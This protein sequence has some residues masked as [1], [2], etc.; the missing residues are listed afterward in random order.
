VASFKFGDLVKAKKH[1]KLFGILAVCL[2]AIVTGVAVGKIFVDTSVVA[3][4]ISGTY[5]DYQDSDEDIAALVK[6]SH[7]AM[8]S[9][10][11]AYEVFEIAQY[12]LY[13]SENFYAVMQG[14]VTPSMGSK[15][16]Q[17]TTAVKTGNNFVMNKL[18]PGGVIVGIDTNVTVLTKYDIS[19][20]K[21]S[22]NAKGTWTDRGKTTMSATYDDATAVNYT[23]AEYED[24]FGKQPTMAILYVV[25]SIT[26]GQGNY[27]AVKKDGD[28]NYTFSVTITDSHLYAAGIY[29]AKDVEFSSGGKPAW[30]SLT[31][32][33]IVDS[34]FNFKSI[35]YQDSY[36]MSMMSVNATVVD[37]FTQKFYFDLDSIPEEDAFFV[38]EV[39]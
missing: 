35:R 9:S 28:G 31:I 30:K 5:R 14:F 39:L 23:L 2:I 32:T 3:Q 36:V 11:S 13:N 27:T 22:V 20:G 16:N 21:V 8:P 24:K 15:Q 34:N 17:V 6:K 37:D 7:S 10:F 25:S 19:A 33:A 12:K 18:S 38:G 29:Y 1:T 26:C 4:S